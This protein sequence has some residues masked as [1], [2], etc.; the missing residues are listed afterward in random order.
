MPDPPNYLNHALVMGHLTIAH[1]P[2]NIVNI[3]AETQQV[4]KVYSS[5]LRIELITSKTEMK[6]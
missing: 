6:A 3:G 1:M 4:N 5:R 2:S